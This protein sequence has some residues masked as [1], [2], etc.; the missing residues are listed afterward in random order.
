MFKERRKR[1]HEEDIQY[2]KDNPIKLTIYEVIIV[3]L[4]STIFIY[5]IT[6][7]Q[8]YMTYIVIIYYIL[9]MYAV[10]HISKLFI[11]A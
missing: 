7:S 4:S 3:I 9:N 1:I 2:C 8:P 5:G 10:L 11:E 6:S